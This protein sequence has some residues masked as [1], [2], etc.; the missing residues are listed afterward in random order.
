MAT[1]ERTTAQ[2]SYTPMHHYN[3]QPDA[4]IITAPDVQAVIMQSTQADGSA[5]IQSPLAWIGVC[6][7]R[8]KDR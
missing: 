7:G 6:Q 8:C 4:K 3:G 1:T 5:C 2:T